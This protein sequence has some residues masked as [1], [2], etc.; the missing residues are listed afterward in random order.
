M[1]QFFAPDHVTRS[2]PMYALPGM[3]LSYIFS[4]NLVVKLKSSLVQA[5]S[6]RGFSSFASDREKRFRARN[7]GLSHEQTSHDV[8][9]VTF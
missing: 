9:S 4:R 8:C 2:R 7:F 6:G 1:L 3:T 5:S